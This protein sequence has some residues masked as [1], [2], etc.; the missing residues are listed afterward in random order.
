MSKTAIIVLSDPNAGEEALGRVFNALAAAHD[1]RRTGEVVLVFQGTGTRWPALLAKPEHPA[2][3]LYEA[4]EGK[5][6]GASAGC[7]V[8][9]GARAEVEQAGVSLLADN[10]VPD[11]PGLASLAAYAADGYRL[12][13]F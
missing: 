3:A 8:V 4:V 1:F 5:V 2:H 9:F 11:T 10:A 7:A 12:L 13:T 6:A